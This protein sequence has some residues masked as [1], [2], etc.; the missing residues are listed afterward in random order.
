MLA[1]CWAALVGAFS[2]SCSATVPL[3]LSSVFEVGV[4]DVS[5]SVGAG[6]MVERVFDMVLGVRCSE[7]SFV[8]MIVLHFFPSL[9]WRALEDVFI[10]N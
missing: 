9:L 5:P 8:G 7:K 1:P 10:R 6:A 2:V 4:E 3:E